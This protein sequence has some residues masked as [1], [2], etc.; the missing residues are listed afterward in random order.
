VRKSL[1]P[2]PPGE[3]PPGKVW[4]REVFNVFTLRKLSTDNDDECRK[5]RSL[6]TA[7]DV[8][9]AEYN[10]ARAQYEDTYISQD[11]A[12]CG[13]AESNRAGYGFGWEDRCAPSGVGP[14][15]LSHPLC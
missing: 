11:A 3:N 6:E 1:S 4:S 12:A 10:A 14:G 15:G 13:D 5:Y 8:M 7:R 9:R 2:T